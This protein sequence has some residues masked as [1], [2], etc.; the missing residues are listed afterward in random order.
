M[1]RD[2]SPKLRKADQHRPATAKSRRP[3]L[4]ELDDLTQAGIVPS[5]EEVLGRPGQFKLHIPR[6]RA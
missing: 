4:P 2:T 1:A 6:A 3:A 5:A